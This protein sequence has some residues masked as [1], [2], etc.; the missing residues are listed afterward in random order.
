MFRLSWS[1]A[2]E[3]ASSCELNWPILYFQTQ[4]QL[5]LNNNDPHLHPSHPHYHPHAAHDKYDGYDCEE[6]DIKL[7]N[8]QKTTVTAAEMEQ[9]V[10]DAGLSLVLQVGI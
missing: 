2:S 1:P 7:E 3:E 6:V 8:F 9:R 5:I 10:K 4:I